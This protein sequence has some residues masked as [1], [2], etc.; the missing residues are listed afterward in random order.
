MSYSCSNSWKILILRCVNCLFLNCKLSFTANIQMQFLLLYNELC[1][2]CIYC[3]TVVIFHNSCLSLVVFS[4]ADLSM[5]LLNLI[6]R[7]FPPTVL[8]PKQNCLGE[9]GVCLFLHSLQWK[10][11][12]FFK[13]SPVCHSPAMRSPLHLNSFF[14]NINAFLLF[15]GIHHLLQVL[16]IQVLFTFLYAVCSCL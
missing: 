1:S 13:A 4:K 6:L 11:L 8:R 3:T 15:S 12:E 9:S 14:V 10:K 7:L 16:P 2:L 5:L